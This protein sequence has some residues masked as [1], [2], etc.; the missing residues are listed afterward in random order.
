MNLHAAASPI[1]RLLLL[2]GCL[3][4]NTGLLSTAEKLSPNVHAPLFAQGAGGFKLEPPREGP[5]KTYA[6]ILKQTN[7]PNL[8]D[9]EYSFSFETADGV[10]REEVGKLKK[11]GDE[12]VTV[13]QG[14]YS[15]SSPEGLAIDVR[16]T[17]DENGARSS[18]TFGT[19]PGRWKQSSALP[20]LTG[21]VRSALGDKGKSADREYLPPTLAKVQSKDYLPPPSTPAPAAKA[22]NEYLPP[23]TR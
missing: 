20:G 9:G 19:D 3:L 22:S 12:L 15:Y 16:Y 21:S 5:V 13:V 8:G 10:Q 18:F 23:S 2:V 6:E 11:V 7:R 1:A 4:L 17:A 14:R